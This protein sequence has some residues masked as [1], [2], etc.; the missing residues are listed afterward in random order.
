M[1][2]QHI[3]VLEQKID[4]LILLCDQLNTEIK[5][6]KAKESHWLGERAKLIDKNEHARVKVEAMISRLKAL[7]QNP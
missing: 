1:E 3:D 7:E 4:E 2:E 6:L 5:S